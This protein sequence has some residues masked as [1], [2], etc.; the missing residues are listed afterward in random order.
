MDVECTPGM[1][2][3]QIRRSFFTLLRTQTVTVTQHAPEER[4]VGET[5]GRSP[6]VLTRAQRAHWRLSWKM[7]LARNARSASAPSIEVTVFG[8]PSAFAAFLGLSAA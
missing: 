5:E 7:R 4:D 8:L 2:R 6:A 1:R 3:C